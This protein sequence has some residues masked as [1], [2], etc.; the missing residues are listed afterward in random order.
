MTNEEAIENLKALKE[1]FEEQTGGS[2]P[3][4]FDN[5]RIALEKQIPKLLLTLYKKDTKIII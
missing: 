3:L 2:Y 1:Y 5:A 4:C